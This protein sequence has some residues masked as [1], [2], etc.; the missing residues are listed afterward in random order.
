MTDQPGAL[1]VPSATSNIEECI[2][3]QKLHKE[4]VTIQSS[5][6]WIANTNITCAGHVSTKY[7][8]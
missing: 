8:H 4:L 6:A 7:I 5:I 1:D 2:I 3:A